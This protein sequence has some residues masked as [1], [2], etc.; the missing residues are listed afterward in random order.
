MEKLLD[1]HAPYKNIKHPKYQ[2]ETK[3]WLTPGL[4]YSINIKNKLYKSF[5]KE[6]GPHKK[7][8]HE[9]QFKIYRN[10]IS[11]PLRETKKSYYKQYLTDNKKNLR[12]VWQT[13]KGI[14]NM[15]SKSDQSIS[16]L[17]IDNQ[18]ITSAKP[19][20]N[21]F[22]SFFTSIAEKINRNIVKAKKP[23]LSYLGPE[24]KNT[25]FLS[26][27]VPKDVEDLISSM[28]TNKASSP[29]SASTNI[30]KLF[31]KEFSKP[32]SD[33]TNMSFNQGVF[34]NILKI[35]NAIP[36]HKKGDKLDC[37]NYRPVS[38]L[39]NNSKMFEKSMHICLVN[40][41]RK[42]KLLFCYQLGF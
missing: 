9:R 38:L 11:T 24:N 1:K 31:K 13:I 26:P 17:L 2:F 32:L 23:D 15:K 29:N 8:N 10:L 14:I 27:T 21:H 41:L 16:S 37:N 30:L 25:I 28:K 7:E 42:N 36:I 39:F 12:L 34:P 35:A 6:K 18:L 40:F 20:S 3:P 5:C 22:N 33:L 19:I 4:A